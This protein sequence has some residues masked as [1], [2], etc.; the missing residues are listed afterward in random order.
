MTVAQAAFARREIRMDARVKNSF[1]WMLYFSMAV[2]AVV[3]YFNTAPHRT[4]AL[5]LYAVFLLLSFVQNRNY[6]KMTG[7]W[8]WARLFTILRASLGLIIQCFDRSSLSG[9]AVM[10]VVVTVLLSE[11]V[12]FCTAFTVVA[13][14]ATTVIHYLLIYPSLG[15]PAQPLGAILLPRIFMVSTLIIARYN[16]MISEK[17][18]QLSE[19]LRQKTD[20][21]EI[22]LRQLKDYADDLKET[23]DLRARDRL[24]RDLHDTLGHMLATASINAQAVT[25]LIDKDASAAKA[26]QATVIQQIQTA[27]QSLRD[28]LSGK[29]MDYSGDAL[30]SAQFISLMRE[31]EKRT[32][33][34]IHIGMFMAEDYDALPVACRSFLYNA[35]MEGLTNGI[36]HGGVTRFDFGLSRS[37]KILY[38]NLR[39]NGTGF[40]ELKYGYGLSKIRRDAQR[41]GGQLKMAG[42]SGCE[43]QI[44]LP[45]RTGKESEVLSNG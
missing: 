14:A 11:T 38:F 16:I 44:A 30:T 2:G 42:Q 41:L 5:A 1:S 7:S 29:T 17:N 21:L 39:D 12:P 33:I 13:M 25:V 22:S 28:V 37:G 9:F 24:M 23:A 3:L 35:L 43:M 31:T 19:L 4:V 36:R 8:R 10:I 18:R 6:R 27:M 32:E 20:E 45:I 34:P 26:R 15:Y 40:Q